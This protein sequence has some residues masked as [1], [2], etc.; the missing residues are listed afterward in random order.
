MTNYDNLT[1]EQMRQATEQLKEM[2]ANFKKYG[3]YV[4]NK[5]IPEAQTRQE[6]Y[7]RLE[8]SNVYLDIEAKRKE[9]EAEIQRISKDKRYK[10][11]F[12]GEYKNKMQDEF[13]KYKTEKL[14]EVK[15]KLNGYKDDLKSKYSYQVSDPQLEATQTNNALLQ[16]AFIQQLDN[17][18]E[19]LKGYIND[20]WNKPQVMSI[21]ENMYKDNANVATQ[22]ATKRKE[23]Q[24]P[25]LLVNKCLNDVT[26]FINNSDYVVNQDYIEKG[27]TE[28]N[29]IGGGANE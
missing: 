20:N 29:P 8:I 2:Q 3:V 1:A 24:R 17:N 25:Y 21:V 4:V 27:I 23:E 28:F 22:I 19:M 18:D 14:T 7:S 12:K 11:E 13:I 16:L 15:A 6:L 26:T 5:D 9:F 10:T